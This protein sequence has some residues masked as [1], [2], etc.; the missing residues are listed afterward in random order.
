MAAKINLEEFARTVERI[1][2]KA[3]AENRLLDNPSDEQLRALV[4]KEEGVRKTI[5]DNYV[6]ES[7]PT[8]RAQAFTKNSVDDTFGKEELELLAKCEKVLAQQRLISIDRTVGNADSDTVVRLIIPEMFAHVAYGGGNLFIPVK[9]PVKKPN[10]QI[11][12]FCA[13]ARVTNKTQPL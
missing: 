7:E 9:R 4:E 5:Y 6:A 2:Q 8:S 13:E 3:K 1:R 12:F 11:I 10:Y